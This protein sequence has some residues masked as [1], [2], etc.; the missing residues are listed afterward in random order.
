MQWSA[1]NRAGGAIHDKINLASEEPRL[2]ANC[3]DDPISPAWQTCFKEPGQTLADRD[4]PS[5]DYHY[6]GR[7]VGRYKHRSS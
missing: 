6:Q 7:N 5:V 4:N 3:N 1:R 2:Y